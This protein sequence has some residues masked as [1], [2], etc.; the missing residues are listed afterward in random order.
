MPLSNWFK[1]SHA[2]SYPDSITFIDATGAAAADFNSNLLNSNSS[3]IQQSSSHSSPHSITSSS[4]SLSSSSSVSNTLEDIHLFN[5][6]KS[7]MTT[8]SSPINIATPTRNASSSPSSQGNKNNS[9]YLDPDSRTSARIMTTGT[10]FDDHMGRS[11]QE[12]YAAAKPIS[13]N[14][15][16]RNNDRPRRESLAGSL[17]GG[18]SWG[19]VSVGS[20]IRDDIIMAGTS[21]FPYQSPSYHSSSYLP[22]LEA[23]FMKD[24]SCCGNTLA[25]L[26]D[27]LQHYEESHAQQTPASLRN[28][29]SIVRAR[30]NAMPNGRA[31]MAAPNT[32]AVQ[33]HAQQQQNQP[34][35]Q[36]RLSGLQMPQ[37]GASVGGIQLMRQQQ[38]SQPATP[39]QK[40]NQGA[41]DDMDGVEDMEMDDAIGP[42]DSTPDTPVQAS[43]HQPVQAAQQ[44]MFGQQPRPTINLNSTMQHSGLRTSQP[45]TPAASSFGI[46][47]NPTVSSV[48]TPTLTA[49]PMQQSQKFSPDTSAPGTPSEMDGDYTSMPMNMNMGN[50]NM[51]MNNMN[52]PFN[53]GGNDL[54][55]ELCIDEPAKRLY[56]PNGGGFSNQRALQQQFAQFGLGQAQFANNADLMRAYQQQQ[57]MASMNAMGDPTGLMMGEEHKPFRC[58]VIGCEKAYKNQNGLKYH[59]THGHQ[60]QQLHENGDGTFSIVNPETSI[61]YSGNEGMEREK[62]YKCD[63]CGKRYKNLNGLKYHK[64]HSTPCD[65]DLKLNNHL[66]AA[67][68]GGL[69]VPMGGLPGIGEEGM[70]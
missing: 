24:F 42:M 23:N 38:R 57:L 25:T 20:W 5:N 26:H 17:V 62:P 34:S 59:K 49:Q 46:H 55:L 66:A 3:K 35:Q 7:N 52:F 54:G 32:S 50:R 65:P 30:E 40:S 33:H 10:G 68:L 29:S 67:G 6:V 41:I 51:N 43:H 27:L 19:G 11:R 12:S 64:Q 1:Q 70:M 56:S 48:N 16:N 60:T 31:G 18:M 28:N 14:N 45:A 22:K 37:A 53:F 63:Y 69:G 9:N 15:P 4:S 44:S 61:P 36:P 2:A 13:M 39:I 21:P 47:N 8:T 58:P